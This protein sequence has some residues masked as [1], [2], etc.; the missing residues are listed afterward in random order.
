MRKKVITIEEFDCDC[1]RPEYERELL[2]SLHGKV[3]KLMADVSALQAAVDELVVVDGAAAAEL[4]E[5]AAE[6]AGLQA[7]EITQEQIDSITEKVTG[8]ARALKQ[9]T[10]E[11]GGTSEPPAEP[12]VEGEPPAEPPAEGEPPAP[13]A[14]GEPPAEPPVEGEPPAEPP[15]EEPPAA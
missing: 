2:E 13:P 10:E 7:G 4:S 12:P 15:A 8:T 11:A 3:N 9:A 6:V 5:L 14:E 1:E